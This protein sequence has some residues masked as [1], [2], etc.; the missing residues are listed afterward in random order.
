MGVSTTKLTRM[1]GG[2]TV[3]GAM[4]VTQV[5]LVTGVTLLTGMIWVAWGTRVKLV[6]RMT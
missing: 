1:T 6:T 2:N 3:E 5:A 4:G